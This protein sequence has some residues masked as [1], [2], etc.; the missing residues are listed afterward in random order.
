MQ[1]L[2]GAL[3]GPGKAA[4][5]K[6][7]ASLFSEQGLP[8]SASTRKRKCVDSADSAEKGVAAPETD[9]KIS[10]GFRFDFAAM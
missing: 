9:K 2:K 6:G 8:C 3:A 5:A 7:L 1:V 10:N 4:K